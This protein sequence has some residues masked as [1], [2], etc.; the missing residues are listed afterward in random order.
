MYIL[1]SP[2]GSVIR[3]NQHQYEVSRPVEEGK[4]ETNDLEKCKNAIIN[5]T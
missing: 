1:P 2:A 4:T 5:N 3:S